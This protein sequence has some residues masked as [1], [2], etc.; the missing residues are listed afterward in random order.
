MLFDAIG[1]LSFMLAYFVPNF[2]RIRLLRHIR[3][4]QRFIQHDFLYDLLLLFDALRSVSTQLLATILAF[5]VDLIPFGVG[6]FDRFDTCLCWCFVLFGFWI[7]ERLFL[8]QTCSGIACLP[9]F[10][11]LWLFLVAKEGLFWFFLVW[12]IE[13]RQFQ[14]VFGFEEGSFQERRLS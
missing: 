1:L 4:V 12:T 5:S 13:T 3:T 2:I 14:V 8:Y 7:F 9:L 6:Y 11:G 10:A